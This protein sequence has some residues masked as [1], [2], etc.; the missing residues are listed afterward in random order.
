M[1]NQPVSPSRVIGPEAE[2]LYRLNIT[3]RIPD[4]PPFSD[5]TAVFAYYQAIP[6]E[7]WSAFTARITPQ[8]AEA[9]VAANPLMPRIGSDGINIPECHD[10]NDED[11][12]AALISEGFATAAGLYRSAVGD[13]SLPRVLR[14][15]GRVAIGAGLTPKTAS[16][17]SADWAWART[18]CVFSIGGHGNHADICRTFTTEPSFPWSSDEDRATWDRLNHAAHRDCGWPLSVL[19]FPIETLYRLPTM[20]KHAGCPPWLQWV[21]FFRVLFHCRVADRMLRIYRNGKV[22]EAEI[23]R[24]S[25]VI[26]H[27]RNLVGLI[28]TAFGIKGND[29]VQRWMSGVLSRLT[30][31]DLLSAEP[32]GALPSTIIAG[33]WSSI[34]PCRGDEW[35]GVNL[36]VEGVWRMDPSSG[37]VTECVSDLDTILSYQWPLRPD[38]A[39]RQYLLTTARASVPPLALPSRPSEL[40]KDIFPNIVT[41]HDDAWI[42]LDTLL[43]A[44]QLRAH[45]PAL[46][47]EL[48]IIFI[49]PE[50][51]TLSSSV[52]QGKT[53][54]ALQIARAFAPGLPA[55]VAFRDSS[56]APDQ[57]AVSE[58]IRIY[59]TACLDEFSMPK[60][61]S[62]TLA[63]SNL[64]SLAT[65]GAVAA[66]RV[67]ENRGADLRLL[68]PLVISSKAVDLTEDLI[69]RSVFFYVRQLT[70]SERERPLVWNLL[71]TNKLAYSI[72]LNVAR[73]IRETGFVDAVTSA[74]RHAASGT[75]RFAVHR[76]I[77]GLLSGNLTAI[78]DIILRQRKRYIE[79]TQIADEQGVLLS[80]RESRD[81]R[82]TLEQF[83]SDMSTFDMH[84]LAD[85]CRRSGIQ[86]GSM[87]LAS[88]SVL[89][90]ARAALIGAPSP[91][92]ALQ[93]LAGLDFR[94]SDRSAVVALQT[95]LVNRIPVHHAI[96]VPC[97]GGDSGWFIYMSDRRGVYIS[98][99]HLPEYADHATL[100]MDNG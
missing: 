80:L 4:A 96:R 78:D 53:T 54:L 74:L 3:E 18:R 46:S 93:Q 29:S 57:R 73:Y 72:R 33:P 10:P 67:F 16:P 50:Q 7:T 43:I 90:K 11:A 92:S 49:L 65:G 15:L 71:S 2:A 38:D 8:L 48:P 87:W 79:H 22:Y 1:A 23:Q 89:W 86:H 61:P 36:I 98:L 51:P 77:A 83:F 63:R 12:V 76:L 45:I 55:A 44:D 64:A 100:V 58:D 62:H 26:S 5:E 81:V 21:L 39:Q 14:Q 27:Q 97:Q 35:A 32:L 30:V 60:S 37:R 31:N 20:N 68:H 42:L 6:G 25:N 41:S 66:G 56:S 28:N 9:E 59:G 40:L 99:L 19:L 85:G 69:T 84:S 75:W 82:I 17:N 94:V 88:A 47:I 52:N 34:V 24:C 95:E 91:G 70:D 13:P